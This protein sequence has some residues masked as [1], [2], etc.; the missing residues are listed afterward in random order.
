MELILKSRTRRVKRPVVQDHYWY[1]HVTKQMFHGVGGKMEFVYNPQYK[2][3]LPR[4]TDHDEWS[5]GND[6]HDIKEWLEKNKSTFNIIISH[7]DGMNV[8][9]NVPAENLS[10]LLGDLYRSGIMAD[11]DDKELKKELRR[12]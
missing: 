3:I 6:Y 8:T 9:T 5:H 12:R 2:R 7:E 11:Y 10:S 4:V 1:D